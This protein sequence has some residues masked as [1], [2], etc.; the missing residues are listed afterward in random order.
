MIYCRNYS[1]RIEYHSFG[2]FYLVR[3]KNV[4]KTCK[5][6]RKYLKSYQCP[7]LAGIITDTQGGIWRYGGDMGGG[8]PQSAHILDTLILQVESKAH[9]LQPSP[10]NQPSSPSPSITTRSKSVN[11]GVSCDCIPSV[12]PRPSPSL[13]PSSIP[14]Q[15][16]RPCTA[17]PEVSS[18][19]IQCTC[20]N[21]S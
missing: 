2:K 4:H 13:S 7:S 10:A 1:V 19:S 5:K 12:P 15:P 20:H 11:S 8:I 21:E 9:T 3:P 16:C 18:R 14:D 17:I 6:A